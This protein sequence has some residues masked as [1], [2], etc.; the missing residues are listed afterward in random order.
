[1]TERDVMPM[2]V[3]EDVLENH[4]FEFYM[5]KGRTAVRA[6]DDAMEDDDEWDEDELPEV[7]PRLIRMNGF[8]N[9]VRR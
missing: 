9:I 1:M 3:E 6:V 7:A 4:V 8:Y 2:D 5:W